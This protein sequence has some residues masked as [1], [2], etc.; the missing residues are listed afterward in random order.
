MLGWWPLRNVLHR[1]VYTRLGER[2]KTAA[3]RFYEGRQA[4]SR[5]AGASDEFLPPK[6][7]LDLYAARC[8]VRIDK[9]CRL[10]GYEPELG[11]DQGMEI[12]T[13]YLISTER[14]WAGN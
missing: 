9:G 13:R 8:S 3:K 12:S 1:A 10:L 6:R 7:L 14:T 4:T 5:S 2:G 11:L